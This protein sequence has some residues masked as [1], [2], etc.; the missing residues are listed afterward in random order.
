MSEIRPFNSILFNNEYFPNQLVPF[1]M[2]FPLSLSPLVVSWVVLLYLIWPCA[3][4]PF[5]LSRCDW[6]AKWFTRKPTLADK[7]CG[8]KRTYFGLSSIS[9]RRAA[10][11][12]FV[13]AL[14][15]KNEPKT[16]SR[17]KRSPFCSGSKFNV[18]LGLG[19]FKSCKTFLLRWSHLMGSTFSQWLALLY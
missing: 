18:R 6:M 3:R 7:L 16:Q 10:L 4:L 14:L 13:K 5:F 19:D 1:S 2:L 11:G 8:W 12:I 15:L 17:N 9:P